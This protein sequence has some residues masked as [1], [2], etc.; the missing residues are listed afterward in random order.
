MAGHVASIFRHPVKGFTPE[1]LAHVDLA[2]GEGF[3]FDRVWAVE[4]GDSGFDPS[5]PGHIGKQ[6]FT[7]LM[8]IARVAAARTRYDEAS[9]RLHA[10]A[11]G[12]ADFAG[13]LSAE[14]GRTGF[15]AWLGDLLGDDPRGPLKVLTAPPTHRFT[16][17]PR[18]Q[19]SLVNLASV[20]DLS[21]RLGVEL[22]PLRFRANLYVEGWE[23]WIEND[24]TGQ[25][26]MVGAAETQVFKPTVRCA[27]TDVN[28]ATAER[29]LEITRALFETYGHMN[30][31]VYLHVTAAGRIAAGDACLAPE[32]V[33][34]RTQ[35][36][37]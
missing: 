34:L 37:A 7:V 24:W 27:A 23:A 33:E 25:P 1:P 18:G 31:G 2:P 6:K 11:E 21:R 29:D 36:D 19:L 3:P 14:A 26:L 28:P 5:A 4:Q 17:H 10:S 13:D 22:D 32:P 16:D 8:N 30:C 20:R 12:M 35:A 9:G 15:A